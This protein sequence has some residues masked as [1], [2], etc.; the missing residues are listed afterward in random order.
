[1]TNTAQQYIPIPRCK[2]SLELSLRKMPLPIG[3]ALAI[4]LLLVVM[5]PSA[6]AADSDPFER[7]NRATYAFNDTFD[8]TLLKPIAT[9]YSNYMPTVAK[10]GIRNFFSNL[11]EVR[12]TFN[13]LLQFKFLQAASDL[14]RFAIN[15]TVGIAGLV[16]VAAPAFNLE[17][18]KQ[19]FGKTLAYWGAEPGPYLVL[20][21]FGPSTVRDAFGVGFDSAVDP[22]FSA[23]HVPSRNSLGVTET[24]SLRTDYLN[25]DDLIIGDEYLFVRGAY[26]QAREY[27]IKGEY[28]EVA[29]EDF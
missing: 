3:I 23:D 12:V 8:K 25:I 15:S 17:K 10:T 21:F 20:P 5:S 9:G 13:D 24:I 4:F 14:G 2:L 19:D 6:H 16:D 26:L 7:V 18:N 27:S 1:M 29:F 28:V 11:D 22:V